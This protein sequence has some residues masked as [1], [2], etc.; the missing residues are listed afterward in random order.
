M[1]KPVGKIAG[2]MSHNPRINSSL[3]LQQIVKS[4]YKHTKKKHITFTS[5]IFCRVRPNTVKIGTINSQFLCQACGELSNSSVAE[6][7]VER[8]ST[9]VFTVTGRV[10]TSLKDLADWHLK[11]KPGGSHL[12]GIFRRVINSLD[13]TYAG[14]NWTQHLKRQT[15]SRSLI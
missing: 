3:K 15:H 12:V 7:P 13:G 4:E 2:D 9:Q 6:P 10:H 1:L 14:N 11:T 5:S 8:L